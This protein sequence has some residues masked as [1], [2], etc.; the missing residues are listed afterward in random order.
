MRE[1]CD[2]CGKKEEYD[3]PVMYFDEDYNLCKKHHR[4]WLKYHKPYINSHKH[5]K[6]TTKAWSKMCEEEEKLFKK[7]FEEQKIKVRSTKPKA[8][9]IR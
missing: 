6:P 3:Y 9:E 5:I 8:K 4:Q 1:K 2:L 7:W